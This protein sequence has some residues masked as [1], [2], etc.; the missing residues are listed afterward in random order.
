MKQRQIERIGIDVGNVISSRDTD[1]LNVKK[2][3]PEEVP[4]AVE[5]ISRI[6]A[7][8][9]PENVFLVSK[10]GPKNQI[11]IRKWLVATDFFIRTGVNPFNVV[12]CIHRKDKAKMAEELR[13]THFIDD[14]L[15]VLGHMIEVV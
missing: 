7:K 3:V 6:V 5:T 4:N 2:L 14:R 15:E 11:R 12:F 13:L 1:V 8:F 10:C 9:G